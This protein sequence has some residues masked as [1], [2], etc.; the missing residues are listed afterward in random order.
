MVGILGWSAIYSVISWVVT[1]IIVWPR[2]ELVGNMFVSLSSAVIVF[3]ISLP[4]AIYSGKDNPESHATA[5]LLCGFN[6][7]SGFILMFIFNGLGWVRSSKE[8]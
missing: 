2:A 6:P 1:T 3:I 4:I 8:D 5:A 7:V